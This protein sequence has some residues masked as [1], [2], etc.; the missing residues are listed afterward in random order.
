MISDA[1]FNGQITDKWNEN[2]FDWVYAT[3]GWHFWIHDI[4]KDFQTIC[5][6][7]LDY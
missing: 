1:Q 3:E 6:L 5:L 4:K 2:I 7:S